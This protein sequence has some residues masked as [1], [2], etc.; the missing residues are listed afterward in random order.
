MAA[1]V[2]TNKLIYVALN[3]DRIRIDGIIA[4]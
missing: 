2:A 3:D 4:G 1:A